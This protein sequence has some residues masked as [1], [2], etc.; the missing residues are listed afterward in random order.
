MLSDTFNHY[1]SEKYFL[2]V[3]CYLKNGVAKLNWSDKY[4]KKGKERSRTINTQRDSYKK[5]SLFYKPVLKQLYL[6]LIAFMERWTI[7]VKL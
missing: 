1:A 5:T 2:C 6:T 3:E 7:K 4:L